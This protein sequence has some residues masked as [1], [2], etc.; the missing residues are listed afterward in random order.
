MREGEIVTIKDIA[1]ESGYAVGTVSRVLN[2]DKRV[3][4]TAY[5][6]VMAVVKKHNFVLNSNARALKQH[7]SRTIGVIVKGT[8]NSLF[9]SILERVQSLMAQTNY[10]VT[11]AYIDEDANEVERAI[12][13][14]KDIKPLGIMFLGADSSNFDRFGVIRIPCVVVTGQVN[15]EA[16]D[17]LASVTTDDRCGA[18]AAMDFLLNLGHTA[19]G[20]LSGNRQVSEISRL[21]FEGCAESM[22]K[23]NIPFDASSQ[24]QTAR[25]SYKSAYSAMNRL[26]I[27]E[28]KLTAVFAMSDT[29]A[30]GAIR[31]LC[32]MGYRVPEDISVMGYDGLKIAS[33]YNP[34][35]TTIRQD[36]EQLAEQSVNIL[37]D[38]ID[39]GA[40]PSHI[41]VP[42]AVVAGDS[43]AAKNG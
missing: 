18:E 7:I 17:N 26:I 41:T 4:E 1:R 6:R 15:A 36:T 5:E 11:A 28:P 8:Q 27:R 25:F 37:L 21:R 39:R 16:F 24:M 9:S 30:I 23:H 35:L 19:I 31:A 3:S 38:M 10:T 22:Q 29:M 42:F 40:S 12:Q 34:K 43:V 33:F 14:V 2:G 20:V 13:L 32:D